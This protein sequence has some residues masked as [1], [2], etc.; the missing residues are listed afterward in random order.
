RGGIEAR[1][2]EGQGEAG[3]W[4]ETALEHE[5][6]PLRGDI[7]DDC[8]PHDVIAASRCQRLALDEET[9]RSCPEDPAITVLWPHCDLCRF[10]CKDRGHGSALRCQNGG[11]AGV[12]FLLQSAGV[13]LDVQTGLIPRVAGSA[14][15]QPSPGYSRPSSRSCL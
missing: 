10:G 1:F 14:P 11:E 9:R 5:H 6:D 8:R 15:G 7:T 4:F 3:L 13:L 12:V 2:R